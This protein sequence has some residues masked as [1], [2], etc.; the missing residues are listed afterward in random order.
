MTVNN[1][2]PYLI[3]LLYDW[4]TLAA[5]TMAIVAALL[6]VWSTL[7]AARME[8]EATVETANRQIKSMREATRQQVEATH[9]ATKLQVDAAMAQVAET[10]RQ[11]DEGKQA[12]RIKEARERKEVADTLHNSMAFMA[13]EVAALLAQVSGQPSTNNYSAPGQMF[14]RISRPNFDLIRL[15]ISALGDEV[16][17][18]FFQLET[19]LER[20]S[21]EQRSTA[22]AGVLKDQ[23]SDVAQKIAALNE[24]TIAAS[25]DASAIIETLG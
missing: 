4:Q 14:A 25:K 15:R 9:T 5:G 10:Q 13:I 3:Q 18:R 2:S 23:V 6:T 1:S 17:L 7:H 12:Q 21:D 8:I 11:S 16:P 20:L 22:T 24:V 19:Q